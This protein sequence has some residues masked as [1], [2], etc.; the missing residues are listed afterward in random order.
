[1][2]W[3]GASGSETSREFKVKHY[4]PKHDSD[5]DAWVCT[6]KIIIFI[7][8]FLILNR[9]A[10]KINKLTGEFKIQLKAISFRAIKNN[11]NANKKW[12]LGIHQVFMINAVQP[13]PP[14][15]LL[16]PDKTAAEFFENFSIYF[17]FS[18][19]ERLKN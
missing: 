17:I 9:N 2:T 11:D 13:P 16:N 18:A 14:H 4:R 1:M 5:H 3:S 6:S 15:F 12:Y 10:I 7:E 19:R 8:R